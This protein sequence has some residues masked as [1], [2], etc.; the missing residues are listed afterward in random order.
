MDSTRNLIDYAMDNDGV[1]FRNQLYASIH[2]RVT[3]AIE[4]KKQEIAGNLIRKESTVQN[5]EEEFE[6]DSAEGL[7]EMDKSQPSAGRD[8]GP[9]PGPDLEAKPVSREKAIKDAHAILNK[10]M[11]KA[12]N[13]KPSEFAKSSSGGKTTETKTGRIHTSGDRY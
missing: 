12:W 3:A 1:E 7:T 10:A 5:T 4:A 8:A 6:Q 2:D 9:R 11:A 13:K